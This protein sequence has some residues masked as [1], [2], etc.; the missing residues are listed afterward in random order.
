MNTPY[1]RLYLRR[2]PLLWW[3]ERRSY[4][5]FV[6]RE[7]S[8]V[9]VAWFVVYLLLLVDAVAGGAPDY[10]RFQDWSAGGGVVA[11]NVVA[12]AFVLLHTVTWFSLAPRALVVR[13]RGRTVPPSWV[14][15]GHYAAWLV[16]T[17]AVA[18]I[19]LRGGP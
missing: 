6:L 4:L 2:V 14:L 18:W 11:V 1:P 15:A 16:L 9:A 17:A 10:Q 5:L 8:S 7:L 3:L 19:V 13:L 12:C